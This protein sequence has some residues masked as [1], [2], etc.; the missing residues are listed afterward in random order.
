MASSSEASAAA[1]F[2]DGGARVNAAPALLAAV[3]ALTLLVALPLAVV[4]QRTIAGDLGSS[5]AAASAAGR[6]DAAWFDAFAG[7]A[8]GV[9]ATF[10]PSVTGA[11][12]VLHGLSSLLDGTS[13]DAPLAAAIVA[14]VLLWSF[15]SGGIVDRYAR[16]GRGGER[17]F[18]A[19][20]RYGWRL[21]RLGLLAL[22]AYVFLFQTLHPVL[23]DRLYPALV[24]DVTA[25]RTA[26]IARGACY[27]LF[28]AALIVVNL[29]IDYAR[30]A[31]VVDDRRSAL[32]SLAA[33]LRFVREQPGSWLLYAMNGTLFAILVIA[34]AAASRQLPAQGVWLWLLAGLGQLAIVARHY[35]KLLFYATETAYFQRARAH[36][37]DTAPTVLVWPDAPAADAIADTDAVIR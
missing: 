5:P 31:I 12:G 8:T 7:G 17:F 2:R 16:D 35:L 14:W 19:C 20:G 29:V 9:G 32:A 30:I 10:G 13:P 37:S 23:F 6:G 22:A 34:W 15:V 3:V 33:S 26:V 27:A 21:A 24:H 25:E 4:L 28:G 36:T 1:A 18:A 11:G